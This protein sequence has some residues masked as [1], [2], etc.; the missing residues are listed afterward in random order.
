MCSNSVNYPRSKK[1]KTGAAIIAI[2]AGSLVASSA[3]AEDRSEESVQLEEVIVTAK[4]R[5]QSLQDVAISITALSSEDLLSAGVKTTE[6]L[7]VAVPGLNITRSLSTI[8]PILRGVG[9]YAVY[10][11][12][13]GA[14]AMYVDEVYHP[15]PHSAMFNLVNV[16]RVEVLRGPQ[17]TLF[18]R[19]STGGL[20]HVVTKTPST[21]TS[22]MFSLGYGSQDTV[23]GKLYA[24]TG[25]SENIAADISLF[26]RDQGEGFGENLATGNDTLFRDEFAA[27]TK[28]L[29]DYDRTRL[30]LSADYNES[31]SD[32]GVMRRPHEG[33]TTLL[34][35]PPADDFFDMNVAEDHE[36]DT[37][38]W[39]V[40][41]HFTREF[42][43]FDVIAVLSRREFDVELTLDQ[44]DSPVPYL[45][46][47]FPVSGESESAELRVQSSGDA[48]LKWVLG[49]YYF[50]A[51][52]VSDRIRIFPPGIIQL[53]ARA[54]G[55]PFEL[56]TRLSR[57]KATAFGLFGE[58]VWSVSD[59]SNI[60]L[61]Y[62]YTEDERD[63]TQQTTFIA[64]A[65]SPLGQGTVVA[66][67]VYEDAETFSE[68]SWRITVDRSFG[69]EG[70]H[71]VF[72]SVSHGFKSGVFN[73]NGVGPAAGPIDPEILDAYEIGFKSV[74]A[75]NRLRING[76]AFFYEY[77][78][79]QVATQEA[80]AAIVSNAAESEIKGFELEM[81][82]A[83]TSELDINMTA[84]WL[85]AEFKSFPNAQLTRANPNRLP[86][87]GGGPAPNCVFIGSADGNGVPRAPD[88]TLSAGANY[89][90]VISPGILGL[91]FNV[92]YSDSAPQDYTNRL[93]IDS[94]TIVN[95]N[96]SL[97]LGE[98]GQYI[99][100]LYGQNLGDE[101][102]HSYMTATG[103]GDLVAPSPGRQYGVTFEYHWL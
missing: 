42:D 36:A 31:T 35:T 4:K 47:Y 83:L 53:T 19:N 20:I 76:T 92:F 96:A 99:I 17:G 95:A 40:S 102:Y 48:T 49:A 78:D 64:S 25:L 21:E 66:A 56:Q 52:D 68:P 43:D 14:V 60:T 28:I 1:N 88:L 22:G 44:G 57:Q 97:A 72:A 59:R 30:V 91:G 71:L 55:G 2:V 41:A 24:T 87:P 79:L 81:L 34:G 29:F 23:E 6:D 3:L 38:Q 27:R 33:T 63:F 90:R 62:R 84:S 69:E 65:L 16:E 46:V 12:F 70:D 8:A 85:D 86:C 5:E 15:S 67:P 51:N 100:R 9:N 32:F 26:N 61:G 18:G 39:G 50:D 98:K 80:G 75:D 13:E 58:A 74:L 77:D 7:A 10:A 11:G 101:E 89:S 103:L 73:A 37:D 45:P 94:Y 82:A 93:E 54:P